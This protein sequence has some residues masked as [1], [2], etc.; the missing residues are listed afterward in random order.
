MIPLSARARAG[1]GLRVCVAGESSYTD[2]RPPSIEGVGRDGVKGELVRFPVV[3]ALLAALLLCVGGQT[4]GAQ[5]LGAQS[6]DAEAPAF[7]SFAGGAFDVNDDFTV[8]EGRM[9]YRS[10]WRPL[11]VAPFAGIMANYDEAFYAYGGVY[12]D[13]FLGERLVLTP[14]FAVGAYGKG[15]SKDLGSSVEFRSQLE[16]SVRL[17][18]R[19]RLGVAVSH[20]SNAGLNDVNPGT[21]SIVFTYSVPMPMLTGRRRR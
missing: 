8:F 20:M 18:N 14:S 3:A 11:Y 10:N 5:S 13:L 21:E 17:D 6:A 9:E 15:S 1:F 7:L 2:P 12:L 19:I 4:V 16:L